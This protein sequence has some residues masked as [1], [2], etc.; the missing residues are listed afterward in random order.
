MEEELTQVR[1]TSHRIVF[2]Y[3]E[4][5]HHLVDIGGAYCCEDHRDYFG[6]IRTD[7]GGR[8]VIRG[9]WSKGGETGQF[10]LVIP[11]DEPEE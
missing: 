6:A 2:D 1:R 4:E 5:T 10:C 11:E 3:K 8:T 7:R 9:T